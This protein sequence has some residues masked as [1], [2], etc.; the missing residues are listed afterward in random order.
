MTQ[1]Y[2]NPNLA[3]VLGNLVHLIHCPICPSSINFDSVKAHAV[4][5]SDTFIC[6][7]KDESGSKKALSPVRIFER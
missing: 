5:G 3:S 6:E 4:A 1:L 2:N 7:S